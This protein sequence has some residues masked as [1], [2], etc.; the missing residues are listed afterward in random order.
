VSAKDSTSFDP[1]KIAV[2][3]KG[4][5][6]VP[7]GTVV[8][9]PVASQPEDSDA[10]LECNGQSTSGYPELAA[11]VGPTVPNYQGMFLRGHGSQSF[12]QNNGSTVGVTSTT[13]NSGAL[14]AVQGDSIRN[15]SGTF[16]VETEAYQHD[17]DG[18]SGV[19]YTSNG[20]SHDGEE[21]DSDAEYSIGFDASRVIPTANENRPANTAVRYLIRAR[22]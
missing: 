18:L 9:W 10:W 22:Q 14:G 12:A 15:I 6:G 13:H 19:F 5:G 16:P 17:W 8:A 11:I 3:A 4:S 21:G 7:V 2:Q 1:T 20:L